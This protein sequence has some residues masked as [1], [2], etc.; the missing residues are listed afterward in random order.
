MS[1]LGQTRLRRLRCGRGRISFDSRLERARNS[2]GLGVTSLIEALGRCT[3]I[4]SF[5]SSVFQIGEPFGAIE[6]CILACIDLV[7]ADPPCSYRGRSS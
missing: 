2:F 4:P 5:R 1:A 3:F 6:R 7:D